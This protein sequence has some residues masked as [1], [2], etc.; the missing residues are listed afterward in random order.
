[1]YT[2]KTLRNKAY[3]AGY[4]IN[5]GFQHQLTRSYPVAPGRWVGYNVEDLTTG[6]MVWDCYDEVRDHLWSLEDVEEFLREVY[7]EA[8]LPF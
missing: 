8:G 6:R 3:K 1:M 5:K 4:R 7:E 2:E